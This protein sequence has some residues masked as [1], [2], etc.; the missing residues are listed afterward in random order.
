MRGCRRRPWRRGLLRLR[1]IR[2]FAGRM[3]GRAPRRRTALFLGGG[4]EQQLL[5]ASPGTSR[6]YCRTLH[7]DQA[8]HAVTCALDGVGVEREA[9][10]SAPSGVM[11]VRTS[12]SRTSGVLGSVWEMGPDLSHNPR[13]QPR[14]KARYHVSQ[15]TRCEKQRA[16]NHCLHNANADSTGAVPSIAN[17]RA[18]YARGAWPTSH[19]QTVEAP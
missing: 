13:Q 11:T 17:H 8:A 15:R 2:C 12:R 9:F 7:L 1:I 18:A 4:I 5:R 6:N 14:E 10:I 3:A 16:V 19:W